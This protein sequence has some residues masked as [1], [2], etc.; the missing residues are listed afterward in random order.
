MA[1]QDGVV[2]YDESIINLERSENFITERVSERAYPSLPT[3]P[4]EDRAR[5]RQS[6]RTTEVEHQASGRAVQG[7]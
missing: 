7:I 2:L 4:L 6:E 1:G 5:T 3:L